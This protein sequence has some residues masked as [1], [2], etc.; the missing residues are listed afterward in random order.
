[1][2]LWAT[3]FVGIRIGLKA[4]DPGELALLRFLTASLTLW[5]MAPRF[6]NAGALLRDRKVLWIVTA[7]GVLGILEMRSFSQGADFLV[8]RGTLVRN[9]GCRLVCHIGIRCA[10]PQRFGSQVSFRMDTFPNGNA[11]GS[12][13]T[14]LIDGPLWLC[15]DA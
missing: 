14:I 7:S 8:G 10:L 5:L 15:W 11:G 1:M 3:A 13:W 2:V 9:A 12:L 6:V 4:Y